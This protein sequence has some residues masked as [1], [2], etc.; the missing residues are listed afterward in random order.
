MRLFQEGK[1]GGLYEEYILLHNEWT[2][3][4]IIVLN[5]IAVYKLTFYKKNA[6]I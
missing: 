5:T 2:V 6:V 1:Y 4:L 3:I